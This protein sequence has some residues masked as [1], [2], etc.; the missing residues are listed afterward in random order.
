MPNFKSQGFKIKEIYVIVLSILSVY[1]PVQVNWWFLASDGSEI[2]ASVEELKLHLKFMLPTF[3]Y[4]NKVLCIRGMWVSYFSIH[5][6]LYCDSTIL[7]PETF[8]NVIMKNII[9]NYANRI[10]DIW[11]FFFKNPILYKCMIFSSFAIRIKLY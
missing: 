1:L 6:L 7:G 2:Q 8:K 9:E 4:F 3:S 11:I 10:W 5:K